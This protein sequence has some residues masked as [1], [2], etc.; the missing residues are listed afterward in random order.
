MTFH[1]VSNGNGQQVIFDYPE[2]TCWKGI[3]YF[4]FIFSIVLLLLYFPLALRM[5]NVD[6][7]LNKVAIYW[8]KTWK[9]D[10]PD[11]RDMHLVSKR[12]VT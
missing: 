5:V 9:F 8:W 2:V 12:S 10:K 6:G 7:D 3:H 1:C 11:I 4:Y